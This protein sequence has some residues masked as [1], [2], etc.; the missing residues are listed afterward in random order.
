M[1]TPFTATLVGA[2][3]RGAD[4]KALVETLDVGCA[5]FHLE[6]EPDNAYD[7]NAIKVIWQSIHVGY[8]DAGCAAWLAAELD[9][10]RLIDSV[11]C[12]R[13]DR[14]A[15]NNAKP[16]LE[17]L[18]GDHVD[19]SK[20]IRRPVASVDRRL[21]SENPESYGGVADSGDDDIPY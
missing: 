20:A 21:L 19:V 14:D 6:R 7:F 13:V 5:D 17:I 15:R 2:H 10:G 4:V 12:V 16:V 1:T 8:V 11:T 9:T 3:F 18:V